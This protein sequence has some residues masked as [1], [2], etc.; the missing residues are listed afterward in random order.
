MGAAK[1]SE[2]CA[3]I[4]VHKI[5]SVFNAAFEIGEFIATTAGGS[6]AAGLLEGTKA[7]EVI[8]KLFV[9]N[10]NSRVWN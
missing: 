4:I 8:D 9:R 1:N 3:K 7:Q 5:Y 2:I 10:T 6:N